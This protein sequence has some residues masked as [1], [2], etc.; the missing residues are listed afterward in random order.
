MTMPSDIPRAPAPV[1]LPPNGGSYV[2]W[3]AIFAGAILAYGL[4]LVLTTFGAAIGLSIVSPQPREGISLRWFTIAAGVWFVWTAISSFSAGAYLTGRMRRRI[5]DATEDEVETRDGAHG[6]VVWAVGA[7]FATVLAASG[8]TNVI[9][10]AASG[11]GSAATTIA[12]TM[13]GPLDYYAGLALRSGSGTV[14]NDPAVRGEIASVLSRS[15]SQGEVTEA[16]R[17]YLATV[18]ASSTDATPEAARTQIDTAITEAQTAWAQAVDTADQA[19]I[20]GAIGAFVLAATLLV[21]AAAAYFA[22]STGGQ[23][24]DN[25]ISFRTFGR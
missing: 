6:I 8:V 12:E 3:P 16:D 2:D 10:T 24:R 11:A 9:G 15:L 5:G 18:V 20:A 17:A 25:N 4:F 21:G 1:A 13:E 23:H 19:R 14:A 22:A 7:V